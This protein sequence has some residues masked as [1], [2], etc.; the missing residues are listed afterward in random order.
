MA[1]AITALRRWKDQAALDMI[2]AQTRGSE[3]PFCILGARGP[4]YFDSMKTG[5]SAVP[6]TT[7]SASALT[8]GCLCGHIRFEAMPPAQKPHL[9]SCKICQRHTGAL[10]TA[11]VE[12]PSTSVSWTGPG[13]EPA[14]YRSSDWS[15]RVFYAECGSTIGAIDD[16]PIVALVV[17]AFDAP[18]SKALLPVSHAFK[19]SAP[20][21]WASAVQSLFG[22]S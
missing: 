1:T 22:R 17:G 11:W 9:C 18:I 6:R 4:T 20:R 14:K 10:T 12:F 7:A 21:W 16:N 15:Y 2:L 3:T 19:S 13:G 5:R 8:G